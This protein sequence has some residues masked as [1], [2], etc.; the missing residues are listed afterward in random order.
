MHEKEQPGPG[1]HAG[2]MVSV[3]IVADHDTERHA[4][5]ADL[6]SCLHALAAQDVDAQFG[7]YA[8]GELCRGQAQPI[9][10]PDSHLTCTTIMPDHIGLPISICVTHLCNTPPRRHPR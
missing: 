10:E 2:P 8:A 7:L 9:H 1:S 4:E 5:L 3:L 6:R